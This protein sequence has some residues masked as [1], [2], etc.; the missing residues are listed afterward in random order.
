MTASPSL[1]VAER[2]LTLDEP[3]RR[4]RQSPGR[5]ETTLRS[6]ERVVLVEARPPDGP[7]LAPLV[8]ATER[9]RDLVDAV[10]L[11][12]MPFAT[13]HVSNLAAGAALRQAGQEVV[14]NVSCRDRNIIA[15]QGLLLGAAALGIPNVFCI[16]GDEPTVGDHPEAKGVF[17]TSGLDLI[18]LAK[19]LRDNGAYASG[20][21]FSPAPALFIGAALAPHARYGSGP[22]DAARSKLAAG[23]DF[24]IT[25]P[26]C[27]PL[28]FQRLLEQAG[29]TLVDTY[30]LA[31]V[32]PI[33]TLKTLR[34]LLAADEVHVSEELSDQL[35]SASSEA[36]RL[37]RGM[38]YA[39]AVAQDA[40][41]RG[42]HGVLVYPF[43]CAVE[44]T[45]SF[46][47]SVRRCL[48]LR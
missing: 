29:H 6:G 44:E 10:Q 26:L 27:D 7:D 21:M 37:Q 17:E 4:S 39:L 3:E 2:A 43:D 48:P 28:T 36:Q 22:L 35:Q 46:C 33:T 11:T 25:Q 14:L 16:R 9:L 30:L 12:D 47:Q 40:L 42:A 18:R 20:R 5:L 24:L 15:Q 45:R 23:A 13:P 41:D 19:S 8:H 1:P 38:D 32:G 31:G 34:A